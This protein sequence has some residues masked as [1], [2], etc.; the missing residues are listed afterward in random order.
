M[1]QSKKGSL[2]ESLANIFV[3][4]G[5]N[6]AATVVIVPVLWDPSSPKLSAF[7]MTLFYTVVSFVRSYALR[8]FFNRA[9]FGN[10]DQVTA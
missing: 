7:Y 5:V 3:G 9:K 8:R 2:T 10:A 1:S 6:W 4:G